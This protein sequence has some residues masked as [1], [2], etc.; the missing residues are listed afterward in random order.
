MS[1][2]IMTFYVR[3]LTAIS[4]IPEL[5]PTPERELL[6]TTAL[7]LCTAIGEAYRGSA[8]R[9]LGRGT[10]QPW[11][12][13]ECRVAA[14]AYRNTR[15]TAHNQEDILSS[16]KTLRTVTRQVKRHFYQAKLENASTRKDIFGMTKWHRSIGSFRTPPLKDP[17]NPGA[18]LATTIEEKRDVL[19]RNLLHMTSDAGDIPLDSPAV[20]LHN[21]PFPDITDG[22]IKNSVFSAGNTAAGEDEIPTA[23]LK[24]C[25]HLIEGNVS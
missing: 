14:Q 21:L 11:W 9:A 15:R 12:N 16:K 22:E 5:P 19:A 20:S 24:I 23:V 4:E 18:T 3:I 6:D 13:D 1:R 8:R 17:L 10:G 7:N 2:D 25:W